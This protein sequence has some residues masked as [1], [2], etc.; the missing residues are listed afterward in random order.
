MPRKPKRPCAYPGCAR[1][2]EGVYCDEHAKLRDKQYNLYHRDP[3][4]NKRYNNVTWRKLREAYL[5][6]FPLC[7]DCARRGIATVA[8]HVHH[9]KPLA[10]GGTNDWSNLRALCQS[11][12]TR[13]HDEMRKRHG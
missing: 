6:R 2:T 4:I 13:T 5:T 11:C 7:E 10:A 1:L 9:I 8:E 3:E 12:H